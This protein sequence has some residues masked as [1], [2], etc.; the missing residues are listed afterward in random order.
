MPPGPLSRRLVRATEVAA[1][2][3]GDADGLLVC[4]GAG[5]GADSGL[6]TF[7]GAEGL[8]RAYP[9]LRRAGVDFTQI[10][11][12]AA[13][14]TTPELA[15]GFYG[16]RLVL[17]RQ[18]VPH[19]GFGLLLRKGAATPRG[20][21]VMTSN[22][23]GRLLSPL[24]RCPACGA[25]ARPN[26]VM[27]GDWGWNG[28]RSKTQESRLQAWLDATARPAV[29]EIGAGPTIPTVRAFAERRSDR[30]IR[31]NPHDAGRPGSCAVLFSSGAAEVL[32][33]LCPSE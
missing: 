25:V 14:R 24:P 19:E 28:S 22:V 18:A 5:M 31:I 29:I 17:Y 2:I 12:P 13:F 21:F 23:D 7:R 20:V 11:N 32:R 6:P 9:A 3:L 4:A 15:W 10:A 30:L 27:F 1:A 16:R 8:W 26:I 33:M